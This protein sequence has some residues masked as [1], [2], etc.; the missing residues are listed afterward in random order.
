FDSDVAASGAVG[1]I[2]PQTVSIKDVTDGTSNSIMLVED[3]GRPQEWIEGYLE[4]PG[5]VG[6]WHWADPGAWFWV[7]DTCGNNGRLFNCTNEN[8]IYSFHTGGC[9]FVYGDGSVHFLPE[10]IEPDTFI[11]LFTRA[12]GDHIG[13]E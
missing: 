13:E 2:S 4:S 7:H 6:G 10:E 3:A 5:G 12:A 8:E 1:P 11:S 9:Q